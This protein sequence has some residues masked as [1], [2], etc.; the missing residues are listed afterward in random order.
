[1]RA[2]DATRP[3]N[4]AAGMGFALV[5]AVGWG[6]N[7]PVPK[8]L[9][10]ELPPLH[11]I[12]EYGVAASAH[13]AMG[14]WRTHALSHVGCIKAYHILQGR[15]GRARSAI[16]GPTGIVRQ[17]FGAPKQE[18]F[19]GLRIGPYRQARLALCADLMGG[20]DGRD[21]YR[22]AASKVRPS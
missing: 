1:M 16:V 7:W 4:F 13:T 9:L 20:F 10:T 19:V 12:V 15:A 6:L 18:E 14:Q 8:Y 3:P 17:I 5:T 2:P 11:L 22:L 21:I